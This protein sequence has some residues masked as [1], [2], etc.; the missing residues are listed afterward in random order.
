LFAKKVVFIEALDSAGQHM[1]WGWQ[2]LDWQSAILQ[3]KATLGIAKQ[4]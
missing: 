1:K 3:A 4:I 2:I